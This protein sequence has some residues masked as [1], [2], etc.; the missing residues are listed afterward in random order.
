MRCSKNGFKTYLEILAAGLLL[1]RGLC[2]ERERERDINDSKFERQL[3]DLRNLRILLWDTDLHRFS[4][5][6]SFKRERG[7]GFLS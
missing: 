4:Q 3:P 6:L 5:I 7:H 2:R 1:F